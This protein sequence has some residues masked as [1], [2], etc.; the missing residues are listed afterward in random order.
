MNKRLQFPPKKAGIVVDSSL[1][2]EIKRTN[3]SEE[4]N[5]D[6]RQK[7][8]SITS[9]IGDKKINLSSNLKFEASV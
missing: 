1:I 2:E 9:N 5:M 7:N 3:F 4:D 8:E 6:Q